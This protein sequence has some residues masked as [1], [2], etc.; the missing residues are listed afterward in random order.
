[1]LLHDFLDFHARENG[2]VDCVIQENRTLSYTQ[3]LERVNR[4]ANALV[5]AGLGVGDRFALLSKNSIEMV[6]I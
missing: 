1:M 3:M 2:A 4:L 5:N 6:V